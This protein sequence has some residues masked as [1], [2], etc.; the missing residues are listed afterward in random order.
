MKNIHQ[1][2]GIQHGFSMLE[3]LITLFILSVGLLGLAAMQA[4]GLKT[5]SGSLLRSKAVVAVADIT[6]RMRA[7]VAGLSNYSLA[8]DE[9][10]SLPADAACVS[11]PCSAT[12]MAQ[13][14]KAQWLRTLQATA[15]TEIVADGSG[16]PGAQAVIA[17][18]GAAGSGRF[19]FIVS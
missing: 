18:L 19:R 6:D 10:I 7:N 2:P 15:Q 8:P 11:S 17:P 9:T 4:E 5:S 16:L 3:V 14:D 1:G 13:F 12:L